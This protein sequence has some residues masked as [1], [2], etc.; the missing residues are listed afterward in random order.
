[1][2]EAV[3]QV[4]LI[5][6]IADD[7]KLVKTVEAKK[8]NNELPEAHSTPRQTPGESTVLQYEWLHNGHWNPGGAYQINRHVL[9]ATTLL[10][11]LKEN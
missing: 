7:I 4:K 3:Q 10:Q 8:D 2:D 1:M 11:E 5:L 9:D 6:K